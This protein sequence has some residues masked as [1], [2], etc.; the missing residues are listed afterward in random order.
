MRGWIHPA[1]D[2]EIPLDFPTYLTFEISAWHF[3]QTRLTW[4]KVPAFILYCHQSK[5]KNVE[6]IKCAQKGFLEEKAQF[7]LFS[8]E[9][10]EIC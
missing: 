7:D 4:Q 2:V 1:F 3:K 10:L 8:A 9:H 6:N 5:K